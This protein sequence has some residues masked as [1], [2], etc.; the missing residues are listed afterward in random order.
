MMSMSDIGDLSVDDGMEDQS[1]WFMNISP[2]KL[3]YGL[4][5]VS[6]DS[7]SGDGHSEE[8]TKEDVDKTI[9]VHELEQDSDDEQPTMVRLLM[10]DHQYLISNRCL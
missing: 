4:S 1:M 2:L 7:E 6:G 5:I 3:L 10:D 8:E 9:T